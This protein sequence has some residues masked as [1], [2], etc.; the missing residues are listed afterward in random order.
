MCGKRNEAKGNP[1]NAA[2]RTKISEVAS[3]FKNASQDGKKGITLRLVEDLEK[4]EYTFVHK[5]KD[6]VWKQMPSEKVVTKVRKSLKDYEKPRA[7]RKAAEMSTS[8]VDKEEQTGKEV[9][10]AHEEEKANT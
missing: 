1:Y 4:E 6:G 2:Y 5:D 10:N 8:D 9:R 3:E 7:K